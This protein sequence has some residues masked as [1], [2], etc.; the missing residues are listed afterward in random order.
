MKYVVP[1]IIVISL[2]IATA[3]LAQKAQFTSDGQLKRPTNYREWIYLTTGV[4]MTYG[5]ATAQGEA[6]PAL[7]NI[8]VEPSSYREFVKSGKWPEGT[9]FVLE[10][11]RSEAETK[12]GKTGRFQS[13][14]IATEASV[15]DSKRFPDGWGYFDL[16]TTPTAKVL[17]QTAACYTCHKNNTAVENTF[18][19]FYPTLMEI[20]KAK[21]TVKKTYVE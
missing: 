9:T 15:K 18:V 14:V 5:N 16:G 6:N 1:R 12:I 13:R 2:V 20:A 4:G 19:Q 10:I 3:L 11:R 17:P 21:G 7:D 8:F